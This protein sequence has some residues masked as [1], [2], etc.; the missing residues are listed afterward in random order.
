MMDMVALGEIAR[1]LVAARKEIA[2]LKLKVATLDKRV[3]N[4]EGGIS[5]VRK[6]ASDALTRAKDAKSRANSAYSLTSGHT[7]DITSLRSK[8]SILEKGMPTAGQL[9]DLKKIISVFSSPA[10]S[11]TKIRNASW[12]VEPKNYNLLKFVADRLGSDKKFSS[13]VKNVVSVSFVKGRATGS[14][15]P[16][17]DWNTEFL[18]LRRK[19]NNTIIPDITNLGTRFD[20]LNTKFNGLST[21]FSGLKTDVGGLKG[22]ITCVKGKFTTVTARTRDIRKN[23][24]EIWDEMNAGI[25]NLNKMITA[26]RSGSAKT[27][28]D[29]ASKDLGHFRDKFRNIRNIVSPR[30]RAAKG[31]GIEGKFMNLEDVFTDIGKC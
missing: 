3:T 5:S 12:L 11:S 19:V 21:K 27:R 17:R 2:A 16:I 26:M 30:S 18:P 29:N 14:F 31:L 23:F 25:K 22:R 7:K 28:L 1:E 6:N 10:V 24:R 15:V 8:V 13:M 4:N 20:G 9:S